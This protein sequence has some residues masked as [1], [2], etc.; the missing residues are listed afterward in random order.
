M[1]ELVIVLR[2]ERRDIYL[3]VIKS[4]EKEAIY[5]YIDENPD[6]QVVDYKIFELVRSHGNG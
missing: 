1:F 3:P 4:M 6:I 2:G 5:R